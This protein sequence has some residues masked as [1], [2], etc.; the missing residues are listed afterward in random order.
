MH[1]CNG[2]MEQA[3]V[4]SRDFVNFQSSFRDGCS[5]IAAAIVDMGVPT[6]DNASPDELAANIRKI[7]HFS[8]IKKG[9]IQGAKHTWDI[10]DITGYKTFE[11][12]QNIFPVVDGGIHTANNYSKSISFSY[13]QTKGIVSSIGSLGEGY[14]HVGITLYVVF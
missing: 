3:R 4:L 10:S 12:Y 5:A 13:D 9:K 11:L 2:S 14:D 1:W 7:K 6:A 8:V